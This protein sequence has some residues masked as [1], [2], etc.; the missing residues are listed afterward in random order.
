MN[1]LVFLLLMF[2]PFAAFSKNGEKLSGK[3]KEVS[4]SNSKGKIAYTDTIHIE[5][6]IGGEYVW[7]KQGGFIYKGTYKITDKDLDMGSRFFTIVSRTPDKLVLKDDAGEYTFVPD[8]SVVANATLPNE[9][10]PKPVTSIDQMVGHWSRYKS[11]SASTLNQVDY[12]RLVKMIDITG[13]SSDGKLGYIYAAK[14]ADNAPSWY[15]ESFSN[16]TLICN[17]K[18]QRSFKVIKCQDNDMVL[19]ENGITYFFRQFK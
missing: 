11:T 4:R 12:T 1:K 2:L 15:I 13:G 10:A 17:G 8:H 3:W 19:E 14:D 5:F 18:D 7:Q 16:Q 9:P 6:L